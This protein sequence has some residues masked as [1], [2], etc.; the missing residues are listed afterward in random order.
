[1]LGD[2]PESERCECPHEPVAGSGIMLEVKKRDPPSKG[3][4]A[5]EV[6]YEA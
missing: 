4:A 1:M 6:Q 2:V 5:L 3:K